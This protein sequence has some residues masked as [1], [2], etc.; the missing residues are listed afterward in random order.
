MRSLIHLYFSLLLLVSLSITQASCGP[1][2]YKVASSSGTSTPPPPGSS[3]GSLSSSGI[4]TPPSSGSPTS[5]SP[6]P[7]PANN[8]AQGTH[9]FPP[10]EILAK[11]ST[12]VRKTIGRAKSMDVVGQ[13]SREKR[14]YN[15]AKGGTSKFSP[16]EIL[17]KDSTS[18]RKPIGRTRSM[19]IVGQASREK[20]NYN[21]AQCST[22]EFS[23]LEI[24]SPATFALDSATNST[25]GSFA[26]KSFE[27]G[28]IGKEE[29]N[30]SLQ[31]YLSEIKKFSTDCRDRIKNLES[32]K[33]L[34]NS[35]VST[36]HI[37]SVKDRNVHSQYLIKVFDTKENL[38]IKDRL[39]I[40]SENIF[41]PLTSAMYLEDESSLGVTDSI[42]LSHTLIKKYGIDS[43][44]PPF[45]ETTVRMLITSSN[46][47]SFREE[48][49]NF[50]K[51]FLTYVKNDLDN[52]EITYLLQEFMKHDAVNLFKFA[53]VLFNEKCAPEKLLERAITGKRGYAVKCITKNF[54]GPI[55]KSSKIN[56]ERLAIN[57]GNEEIIEAVSKI[58]VIAP[59]TK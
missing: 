53:V 1:K 33:K 29:E 55:K 58:Q 24:P 31:D 19:D 59:L 12:S 27:V 46:S 40:D 14:N 17:A 32:H 13:A 42:N 52:N 11:D 15:P 43:I 48:K 9:Q 28:N 6:V 44:S 26:F 50:S 41:T 54:E 51:T 21:P 7:S 16:L 49:L 35:A 5:P 4:S 39:E 47:C 30:K 57:S 8:A 23:P 45:F 37:Q 38:I 56:L 20:R 18:V 36:K 34:D 22:S 3:S 25:P 10:P 2:P